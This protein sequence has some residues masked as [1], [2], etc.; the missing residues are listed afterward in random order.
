MSNDNDVRLQQ[1]IAVMEDAI[2]A[3]YALGCVV[4]EEKHGLLCEF[5]YGPETIKVF[6]PE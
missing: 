2:K 3:I 5:V 6:L 4:G 1:A